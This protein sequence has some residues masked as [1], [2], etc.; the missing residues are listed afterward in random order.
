MDLHKVLQNVLIGGHWSSYSEKGNKKTLKCTISAGVK[1]VAH[2]VI[3]LG[4]SF[5]LLYDFLGDA[6]KPCEF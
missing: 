2:N 4:L 3:Q 1:C 5:A 6:K